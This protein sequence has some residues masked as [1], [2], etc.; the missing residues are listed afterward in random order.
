VTEGYPSVINDP[1]ASEQVRD[2]AIEAVGADNVVAAKPM[3]GGEDFSYFASEVPGCF[4]RIGNGTPD[5]PGH[6]PQFDFDDRALPVGMLVMS[7]LVMRRLAN[8]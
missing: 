6:S 4:F 7:T 5:R 1:R 2:A 8:S 3:M